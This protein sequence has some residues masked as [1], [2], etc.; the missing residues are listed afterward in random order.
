MFVISL[1]Q[2]WDVQDTQDSKDYYCLGRIQ[3]RFRE[4]KYRLGE[5]YIFGGAKMGEDPCLAYPNIEPE[6]W[7]EFVKYRTSAAFK[8]YLLYMYSS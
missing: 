8:V 4:F 1:Q 6:K 3:G 5:D 2:Y 7:N